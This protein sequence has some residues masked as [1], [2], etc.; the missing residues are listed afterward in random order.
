[1]NGT[2]FNIGVTTCGLTMATIIVLSPALCSAS[3]SPRLSP[4]N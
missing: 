2:V 4:I 1:M 3:T